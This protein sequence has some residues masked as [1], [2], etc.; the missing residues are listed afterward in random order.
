MSE[1]ASAYAVEMRFLRFEPASWDVPCSQSH[2]EGYV[3]YQRS[4][5]RVQR[6]A[7]LCSCH[8]V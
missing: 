8:C 2:H 6:L 1:I 7:C 3:S 5:W 4:P